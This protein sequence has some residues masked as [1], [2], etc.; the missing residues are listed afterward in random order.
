MT[1][2]EDC[3][4]RIFKRSESKVTYT[5]WMRTGETGWMEV[6][7]LFIHTD[8]F[9]LRQYPDSVNLTYD[10]WSTPTSFMVSS[11]RIYGP[12][13]SLE[14]WDEIE[15]ACVLLRSIPVPAHIR[16]STPIERVVGIVDDDVYYAEEEFWEAAMRSSRYGWKNDLRSNETSKNI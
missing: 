2:F 7:D 11:L 8:G 15:N 16:L 14:I 10:W 5:D 13:I 12:S 1:F 3:T 4:K 6:G 9:S